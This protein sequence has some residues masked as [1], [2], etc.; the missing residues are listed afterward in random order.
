MQNIQA[1]QLIEIAATNPAMLI[2][3]TSLRSAYF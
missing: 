1:Y 2:Q 3:A